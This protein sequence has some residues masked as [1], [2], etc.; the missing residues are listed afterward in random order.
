[1][2]VYKNSEINQIPLFQSWLV[3]TI[4]DITYNDLVNILGQPTYNEPSGDN[5]TQVEWT[6]EFEGNLFYIY[7][8]KTYNREFTL[9]GLEIWNIGGNT[10]PSKLIDFIKSRL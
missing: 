9:N 6:I 7:D 1:M 5:K 4:T 2:K 10:D 8:W 3:G